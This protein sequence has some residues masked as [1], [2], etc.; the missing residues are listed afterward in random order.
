MPVLLNSINFKTIQN[1]DHLIANKKLDPK[2][3][4]DSI[5]AKQVKSSRLKQIF[6]FVLQSICIVLELGIP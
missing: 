3:F 4:A 5:Q 1:S 6:I 2:H